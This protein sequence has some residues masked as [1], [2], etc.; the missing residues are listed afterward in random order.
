MVFSGGGRS[1]L[2]L[3]LD[4]KNRR[5]RN[6]IMIK[7]FTSIAEESLAGFVTQEIEKKGAYD[8]ELDE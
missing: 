5:V 6:V 2:I 8:Y 1:D 7:L 3:C 4:N